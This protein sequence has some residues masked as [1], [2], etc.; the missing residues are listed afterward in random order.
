MVEAMNEL[1]RRIQETA[2]RLRLV[3]ADFA[4]AT[5]EERRKYLSGEIRRA[6]A[7]APAEQ[8]RAFLK[9]LAER[10][11]CAL[12]AEERPPAA[13]PPAGTAERL[14]ELIELAGSLPPDAQMELARRLREAGLPLGQ[15]AA[16][17]GAV[18][19]VLGVEAVPTGRMAQ[20]LFLLAQFGSKLDQHLKKVWGDLGLSGGAPYEG[21]SM[22]VMKRF[23]AEGSQGDAT[24]LENMLADLRRSLL[25]LLAALR[26]TVQKFASKHA[27]FAPQ[28]IKALARMDG[29]R[30]WESWELKYW[31]KYAEVG[32]D[33]NQGSIEMEFMEAYRQF[34][35]N[36]LKTA[37]KKG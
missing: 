26:P 19:E 32:A 28:E 22:A 9:G 27:R 35:V 12:S 14:R 36:L 7:G 1:D 6:L 29:K 24:R 30:V 33:M 16:E 3:Q 31:E 37:R 18:A 5:A 25:A 23:L 10:F 17:S 13:H 8:R 20:L 2:N 15:A 21:D 34:V 11:P 4:D